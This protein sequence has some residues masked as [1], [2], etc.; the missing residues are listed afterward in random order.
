MKIRFVPADAR[1][2]F[3]H[4]PVDLVDTRFSSFSHLPFPLPFRPACKFQI[5][6][7]E[8]PAFKM[9]CK[10]A[11]SLLSFWWPLLASRTQ[12]FFKLFERVFGSSSRIRIFTP[13][14]AF[15]G[16]ARSGSIFVSE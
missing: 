8:L 11:C 2:Y 1:Q 5:S 16:Y 4:V 15:P 10:L 12:D 9:S 3:Y 13:R 14:L 7:M 6:T